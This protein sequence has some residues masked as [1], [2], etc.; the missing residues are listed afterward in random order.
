M[1]RVG[2]VFIPVANLEQSSKWYEENLGVKKIDQWDGG[3]GFY[4]PE[5]DTQLGL[6]SVDS[7]QI[8]EFTAGQGQ[9]NGYFNFV[10]EDIHEAYASFNNKGICTSD[11]R[12]FGGMKFFDFFDLDGNPF[13]VVDEVKDSPFHREN[14]RKMQVK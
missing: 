11:I 14:V 7:P 6:V 5:S 4:F 1:F 2:S 12:E 10:V 13:S 8:S 9:K 3:A